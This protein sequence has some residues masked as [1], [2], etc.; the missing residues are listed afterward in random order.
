MRGKVISGQQC[1]LLCLCIYRVSCCMGFERNQQNSYF[2]LNYLKSSFLWI[3][4]G[5]LPQ[6]LFQVQIVL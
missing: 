5:F 1:I 2:S 6:I 3:K 4:H